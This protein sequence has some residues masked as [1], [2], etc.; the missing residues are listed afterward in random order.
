[1]AKQ[2]LETSQ[3][4]VIQ[5]RLP[6][7]VARIDDV[8]CGAKILFALL[9]FAG[10]GSDSFRVGGAKLARCMGSDRDQIRKWR[11]KLEERG[12]MEVKHEKSYCVYHLARKY[13]KGPFIPLPAETMERRDISR[14]EKLVLGWLLYKQDA[15]G[16]TRER[17]KDMAMGLGISLGTIWKALQVMESRGEIQVN[18]QWLGQGKVNDYTL[19]RGAVKAI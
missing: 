1:M 4:K 13:K 7:V 8:C 15:D 12:L 11:M 6:V 10:E 14:V 2:E 3:G 19:N 17:Q 5:Y 16:C 18:H 9:H